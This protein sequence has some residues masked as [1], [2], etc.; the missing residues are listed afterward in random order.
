[1]TTPVDPFWV[2]LL[3][4]FLRERI[5]QRHQVHRS[6]N[7]IAWLGFDKV[8]RIVVGILI[9]ASVAR[10]LGPSLFGQL[11]YVIAFLTLFLPLTELGSGS[12][13][14]RYL[15]VSTNQAPQIL[16]SAAILRLCVGVLGMGLALSTLVISYGADSQ[17]VLLAVLAC[18]MFFGP[19]VDVIDLWF[20]SRLENGYCVRVKLANYLFFSF[21]KLGL[22]WT[23]SPIAAFALIYSIETLTTSVSL[24]ALYRRLKM[25]TLH[26]TLNKTLIK[27][28]IQDSWPLMIGVLM[29]SLASRLDFIYIERLIGHDSI[30]FYAIAQVLAGLGVI[31]PSILFTVLVPTLSHLRE[32]DEPKFLKVLQVLY[33]LAVGWGLFSGIFLYYFADAVVNLI[34]GSSYDQAI[35]VLQILSWGM[36]FGALGLVQGQ[37]LYAKNGNRIVLKQAIFACIAISVLDLI[38]IPLMGLKG[39][40]LAFVITQLTSYCLSNIFFQPG[41]FRMQLRAFAIWDLLGFILPSRSNR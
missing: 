37:W 38:L 27:K 1:M 33:Q 25:P 13:I 36:I 9:S 34:Y 31:L 6:I 22:I 30:A 39:A 3:P 2:R 7:S 35:D 5:T 20:Q 8:I 10:Y 26:W 18:G 41:I 4:S 12:I 15:V 11:A 19:A 32:H 16:C 29:M 21:T 40:A 23:Q 28:I 24:I 14:T 17:F